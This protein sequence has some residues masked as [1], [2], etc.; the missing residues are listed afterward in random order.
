MYSIVVGIKGRVCKEGLWDES[1]PGISFDD[2]GVSNFAKNFRKLC[3]MY[4]RGEE[5]KKK[6]NNLVDI[7]KETS[8][9]LKYDCLVGVSGGTDSSFLLHLLKKVYGL[10]V[11]AVNL[12]NGWNSEIAVENIKKMT[13]DLDIDLYTWVIDYEEVKKVLRAYLYSALPWV[14]APTDLSINTIL[15]EVARKEK[16]RYI[17]N[18]SDFRTEGKQPIELTYIDSKQFNY[19]IKKFGNFSPK[20]YPYHSPVDLLKYKFVHHIDNVRPYY[21]LDYQK[22]LAQEFLLKN[23]N[24]TYYGGHHHENTFT[25]FI[26]GY[27]MPVK[28]G[29]DKR[30][31]TLSA[32]IMTGEISRKKALEIINVP[33]YDPME[34]EK[35]KVYV[36]K[37]LEF[38]LNEINSL[39]TLQNKTIYDYPSYLGLIKKTLKFS[40]IIG[41]KVFGFVPTTFN[42]LSR[43]K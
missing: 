37:K 19:I 27:W 32:Q 1:I 21:Y 15:Y 4:P 5:G 9:K 13:K 39:L 2:D 7:I 41:S 24:W 6:W 30:K 3:E 12:D 17:M 43:E 22:K 36:A 38:S 33:A 8:K 31:I 11:L 10:R 23:Y 40:K 16:I 20:Q 26:I 35:D 42:E 28:F 29:I 34:M 14:D 25:K 18:G